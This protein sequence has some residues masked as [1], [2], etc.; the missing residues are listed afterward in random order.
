MADHI[1]QTPDRRIPLTEVP[2]ALRTLGVSLT[3]QR[4]WQLTLAGDIPA[5]RQGRAWMVNPDDLPA[6]AQALGGR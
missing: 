3:Y 4:A 1:S 5:E 2:R 6:V